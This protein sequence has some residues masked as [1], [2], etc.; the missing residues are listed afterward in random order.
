MGTCQTPLFLDANVQK[1]NRRRQPEPSLVDLKIP[2]PRKLSAMWMFLEQMSVIT[3]VA[4]GAGW[5]GTGDFL[6]IIHQGDINNPNSPP[7]KQKKTQKPPSSPCCCTT[8]DRSR[9]SGPD[10]FTRPPG[11]QRRV[12]DIQTSLERIVSDRRRVRMCGDVQQLW[13][14][15][16]SC[17]TSQNTRK[18]KQTKNVAIRLTGW[19]MFHFRTQR[20]GFFLSVTVA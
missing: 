1:V 17:V 18:K 5:G 3:D 9:S 10:L 12:S 13:R 4:D 8:A 6:Q 15:R 7:P 19:P 2:S 14:S 11:A 16:E 20:F